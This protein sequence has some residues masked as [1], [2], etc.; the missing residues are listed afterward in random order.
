[1]EAGVSGQ[2][3]QRRAKVSFQEG[4]VEGRDMQPNEVVIR[5]GGWRVKSFGGAEAVVRR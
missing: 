5:R 3:E 2:R 1:M 4:T